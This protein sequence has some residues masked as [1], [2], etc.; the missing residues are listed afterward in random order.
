M[1]W[2]TT[3]TTLS[4]ATLG[5]DTLM[6]FL[7]AGADHRGQLMWTVVAAAVVVLVL[8]EAAARLTV[9]SGHTLGE[10]LLSYSPSGWRAAARKLTAA[11]VLVAALINEAAYYSAA[12]PA[13]ELLAT[14]ESGRQAL[15][16]LLAPLTAALLLA[17]S[18]ER[19]SPLLSVTVLLMFG[20]SIG[21][22]VG[23]GRCGA[24]RQAWASVVGGRPAEAA[25]ELIGGAAVPHALLVASGVARGAASLGGVRRGVLL[26]SV[27][28]A[29]LALLLLLLGTHVPPHSVEQHHGSPLATL[30]E[31]AGVL[32]RAAGRAAVGAL[33]VVLLGAGVTSLLAVPLAAAMA[34]EDLLGL[35]E[36]AAEEPMTTEAASARGGG[37]AA[38]RS[39]DFDAEA[40]AAAATAAAA[41]AVSLADGRWFCCCVRPCRG[42]YEAWRRYYRALL[43]V[44]VALLG[45]AA[46][47]AAPAA[48][49][50]AAARLANGV[51]LPCVAVPL[52]LA[53]NSSAMMAARPQPGCLNALLAPC[54]A[55]A[56]YLG[57]GALLAAL[58]GGTAGAASIVGTAPLAA[59]LVGALLV[60]LERQ[61]RWPWAPG[62]EAATGGLPRV[63][64]RADETLISRVDSGDDS[65][66]EKLDTPQPVRAWG[67]AAGR[68]Y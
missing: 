26:A 4:A 5:P 40:S 7:S 17:G 12:E 50:A 31:I 45:R 20:C 36:P 57:L 30:D 24:D 58:V 56:L 46:A 18:I 35:R 32:Q 34:V 37:L 23:A 11:F 64:R 2:F 1:A 65:L 19:L 3:A 63:L 62:D 54:V 59:M 61:R 60:R 10:C 39:L 14:S 9:V 28:S 41:V 67:R 38:R 16:V 6:L 49:V 48:R 13:V 27:L 33:G 53:L 25:L 43:L 47:A 68:G 55:L 21:A 22:L 8:H 42:P 15:S 51:A 44:A 52:L 66:D 29:V